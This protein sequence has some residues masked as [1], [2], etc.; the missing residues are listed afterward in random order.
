MIVCMLSARIAQSFAIKLF[1]FK[2]V[3]CHPFQTV[4]D[5]TYGPDNYDGWF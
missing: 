3:E 4:G 1:S 5:I 2:A